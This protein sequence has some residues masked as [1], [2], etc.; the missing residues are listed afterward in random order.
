MNGPRQYYSHLGIVQRAKGG[1]V[2]PHSKEE[3]L[4]EIVGGGGLGR[5]ATARQRPNLLQEGTDAFHK[6]YGRDTSPLMLL[7]KKDPPPVPRQ[8]FPAPEST[9]GGI[10]FKRGGRSRK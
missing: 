6:K 3:D 2:Y 8:Y 4:P 9:L 1:K 7:L 10:P 5:F